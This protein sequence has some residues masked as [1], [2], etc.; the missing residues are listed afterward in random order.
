MSD[1]TTNEKF[2]VSISILSATARTIL[3]TLLNPPKC[4]P[5]KENL[6]RDWYGLADLLGYSSE[7]I[8][9][10]RISSDPTNNILQKWESCED[11]II[12]KLLCCLQKMDRFD[13]IA[14]I[15]DIIISDI[16]LYENSNKAGSNNI[17]TSLFIT[18][19]DYEYHRRGLQPIIYHA[20]ILYAP[21]DVDFAYEIVSH[22]ENKFKMNIFVPERD[23]IVGIMEKN[24]TMRIIASRCQKLLTILSPAFI[25]SSVNKYFLSF[26]QSLGVDN[27]MRKI[28]PIV[29]KICDIPIELQP[30]HKLSYKSA[31]PGNFYEKLQYSLQKAKCID[32]SNSSFKSTASING[33]VSAIQSF[34]KHDNVEIL[35]TIKK[36]ETS[37]S[38]PK[39]KVGVV[40][41]VMTKI[42]IK[43]KRSKKKE[44]VEV[45]A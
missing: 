18:I 43:K 30:I 22:L 27:S 19:K 29:Y 23:L 7:E 16:A 26:A 33:G 8:S 13:I 9:L 34:P 39:K 38:I 28:I 12:A 21:E 45:A 25:E 6:Q 20:S 2:N 10:F 31:W 32:T 36:P 44:M 24:A 42:G 15:F 41:K 11:S 37:G 1:S 3:S 5:T 17:D 40:Q 4:I 35:Q 14:D